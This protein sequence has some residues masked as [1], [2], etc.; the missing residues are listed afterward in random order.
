MQLQEILLT[1]GKTN[2]GSIVRIENTVRRPLNSNSTF[3]H[4]FLQY[5]ENINFDASP[6]FLGIDEQGREIITFI[7]GHVPS[8]LEYYSNEQLVAAALIIRRF[9]DATQG[10]ELALN[11][12]VIC[13]ND[14]SPCNF[15]FIDGIPTSII[16]FDMAAPGTRI[17]DLAY[18]AWLWLDIGNEEIS[19]DD[20]KRRL[21]VFAEAYG[22]SDMDLLIEVMSKRQ[23]ILIEEGH[24]RQKRCMVKWAVAA[25]NWTT[26]HLI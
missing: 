2:L 23:S 12:E 6:R 17:F 9:H 3:V 16:D 13:H 24:R 18:A 8:N 4:K 15:V 26:I 19:A 21:V 20:Q 7:E 11:E 10:C 14:L 22:I 1:G 25:F 5:L